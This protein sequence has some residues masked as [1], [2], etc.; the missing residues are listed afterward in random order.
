VDRV[1]LRVGARPA[2]L[3]P[4]WRA[5]DRGAGP[6]GRGHRL[7]DWPRAAAAAAAGLV[8]LTAGSQKFYHDPTWQLE[9]SG[10]ARAGAAAPCGPGRRGAMR[11]DNPVI[12]NSPSHLLA[13]LVTVRVT[14]R[15]P[16]LIDEPLN[17]N[18]R[19]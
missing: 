17:L 1:R 13:V 8:P 18:Y 9:F 15:F 4:G 14:S 19:A 10:N 6:G 3:S 5:A 16:A 12:M 2:S 7:S 11:S